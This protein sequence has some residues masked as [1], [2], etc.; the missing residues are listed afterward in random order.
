MDPIVAHH[1]ITLV[2]PSWLIDHWA[3]IFEFAGFGSIYIC[4]APGEWTEA[5]SDR[6]RMSSNRV[7]LEWQTS[8]TS[9]DMQA[10]LTQLEI[11]CPILMCQNFSKWTDTEAKAAGYWG[12]MPTGGL[13]DMDTFGGEIIQPFPALDLFKRTIENAFLDH[14]LA[15]QRTS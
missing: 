11:D 10:L 9:Q 1:P 15:R 12:V 14:Q 2:L 4:P 5:D 3:D 7:A 8:K 6:V 13:M